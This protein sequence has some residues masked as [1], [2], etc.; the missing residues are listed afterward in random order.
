MTHVTEGLKPQALWTY[1]EQLSAIPR[2]SKNESAV[3]A[4]L[5]QTGERL[6]AEVREDSIGNIVLAVPATPGYESAPTVILQSHMDMVCEKNSDTVFDFAKEAIRLLIE[7]EWLTADNT[8]LGADNGIGVAAQLAML[9]S[10]DVVHGPLE[11]LFTVDEETGLTGAMGLDPKL[12]TGRIML[13]LDS[14]EDGLLYVGCAGGTHLSS[15][16]PLHRQDVPQGLVPVRLA[17]RGLKGGHSGCDIHLNRG[18]ALKLLAHLLHELFEQAAQE[19]W[20]G[21]LHLALL[22][23]GSAHNAIPREGE[24]V[25]FVHPDHQQDLDDAAMAAH[26]A[27]SD[28]FP[29]EDDLTLNIDTPDQA[30]TSVWQKAD[31]ETI[32]PALLSFHNGIFAMSQDIPGLVETSN[33]LALARTKADHLFVLNSTRSSNAEAMKLLL[34]HNAAVAHLAKAKTT[35]GD[36]YPG[37]QPNMESP[38]LNLARSLYKE[39]TGKEPKITA[40]HAGLECGLIGERFP[41]M[42]MLSFGPEIRFPHSPDEKVHIAS[43]ANF[44]TLLS[45]LLS[46]IA[47]GKMPA[48]A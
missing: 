27:L 24:A 42:D 43:V 14:E 40:I 9:E 17:L 45:E 46:A 4:F 48:K 10:P 19:T 35:Q 41:G 5:R 32:L 1:F 33:S 11:L 25:V 28:A 8:T 16:F 21:G 13:N 31:V 47:Q 36:G 29:Y 30:P 22:E 26:T 34:R 39:R 37:W 15:E 3:R 23:A 12:L 44:W 7:G 38:V 2:C 6:G 20:T 18:N